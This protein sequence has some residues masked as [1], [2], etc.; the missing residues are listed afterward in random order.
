VRAEAE[1]NDALKALKAAVP[2]SVVAGWIERRVANARKALENLTRAEAERESAAASIES[3]APSIMPRL[4]V[5][6]D[7]P[8]PNVS[9]ASL[10]SLASPSTHI[11]FTPRA[12][13][14]SPRP[15]DHG[16]ACAWPITSAE[17]ARGALPKPGVL[18]KDHGM[19]VIE[20][21][22]KD[23]GMPVIEEHLLSTTPLPSRKR[24][25]PEPDAGPAAKLQ[26]IDQRL[27]LSA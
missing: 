23:H 13:V 24:L 2:G 18:P 1:L 14:F 17:L 20:E 21:H 5:D 16:G 12:S 4:L 27:K 6:V 7:T 22:L 9:H 26:T 11:W 8:L 10:S 25:A 3:D 15:S 19:P